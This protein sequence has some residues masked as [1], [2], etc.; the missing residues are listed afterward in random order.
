MHITAPIAR[1]RRHLRRRAFVIVIFILQDSSLA[2][3]RVS[4]VR[5]ASHSR[6]YGRFRGRVIVLHAPGNSCYQAL[7]PGNSCYQGELSTSP[8]LPGPMTNNPAFSPGFQSSQRR[9]VSVSEDAAFSSPD[10]SYQLDFD[11][12]TRS[13]WTAKK[14]FRLL[15]RGKKPALPQSLTSLHSPL[16]VL[17][18]HFGE[19]KDV[20][21]L[22]RAISRRPRRSRAVGKRSQTAMLA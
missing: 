11:D 2:I 13:H 10:V 17:E 15:A 20:Q 4:C 6:R 3:A 16:R 22:P 5:R 1:R 21:S 12:P 7:G 8:L 19:I 18:L 14:Q 9:L